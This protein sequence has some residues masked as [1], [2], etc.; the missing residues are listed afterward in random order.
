MI[1]FTL[2]T[3]EIEGLT[4]LDPDYY[5]PHYRNRT[6]ALVRV[7][8]SSL[9]RE[10]AISMGPAYSSLS[11]GSNDGVRIAKI[12]DVTNRRE[13]EEWD[14]LTDI[15]FARFGMVSLSKDDILL[16]MTGDPPDVGKVFMPYTSFS[17]DRVL[18]FNQRVAR[19]RSKTANQFYLY[20]FLSSER[21]RLRIEQL[22]L[23]IRQRNVSVPDLKSAY[24]FLPND[25]QDI[26]P[27]FPR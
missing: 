24:V 25:R 10:C 2:S 12:G 5:Q 11:F 27:A 23:G 1:C 16:T 15:E 22:A 8:S 14:Q 7:S 17:S 4:R 18:A 21:F 13:D 6:S 3:T 9:K 19:L 26:E 20:A